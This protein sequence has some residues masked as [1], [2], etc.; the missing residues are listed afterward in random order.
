MK[1]CFVVLS[2]LVFLSACDNSQNEMHALTNKEWDRA[3]ENAISY[4]EKPYM[5]MTN[6]VIHSEYGKFISCLKVDSSPIVF[7]QRRTGLVECK[8]TIPQYSGGQSEIAV[9]CGYSQTLTGCSN[10]IK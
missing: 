3:N 8:G 6:G 9:F 2:I 4:F 7:G 10:S 5:V 1:S